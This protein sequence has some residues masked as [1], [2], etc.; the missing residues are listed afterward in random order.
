M[1]S[2][3][4]GGGRI[5]VSG[6]AV[7][8]E[9]TGAVSGVGDGSDCRASAEDSESCER[10]TDRGGSVGMGGGTVANVWAEDLDI[11]EEMDNLE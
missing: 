6:F 1:V 5:R 4:S 9:E 11:F 7:S 8:G 3:A 10:R 2:K